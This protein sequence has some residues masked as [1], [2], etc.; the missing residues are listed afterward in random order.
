VTKKKWPYKTDD[1]LKEV[2]FRWNFLSGQEKDE[3][4]ILLNRGDHIDRFDC[5][6][7]PLSTTFQLYRGGQFY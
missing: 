6:H 3:L 4:L 1:L 2:K 5:I 7:F